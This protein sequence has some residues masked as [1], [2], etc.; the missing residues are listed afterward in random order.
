MSIIACIDGDTVSFRCAAANENADFGLAVWQVDQML[1]RILDDINAD[2]WKIYLGGENNFRYGI[3][4]DYKIH[5]RDKPKPKHLEGLRGYL[6]SDWDATVCDGY[7]ADDALGIYQQSAGSN[8][9]YI[10]SNDKDLL[11]IPGRHYNFI[12]REIKEIDEFGGAVQ[13]Y[14]QLLVG[15]PADHIRGCSGIGAVKAARAFVGCNTERQLYDKC[16]ELYKVAYK[17]DWEQQLNLAAQLLYVWR[18]DPDS[19]TPPQEPAVQEQ[20]AKQSS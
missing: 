1:T 16:V 5:R 17:D 19:W 11:Q 8:M 7:E 12:R 13:F 9:V 14:T 20:E 2:D 15:D 4:P 6:V 10:C 3:Y 18:K